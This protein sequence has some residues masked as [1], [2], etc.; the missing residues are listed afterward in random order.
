[1][2]DDRS[3]KEVLDEQAETLEA[4]APSRRQVHMNGW[5]IVILGVGT[6]LAIGVLFFLRASQT[7]SADKRIC[8]KVDHLTSALILFA[9]QNPKPPEGTQRRRDLDRF[10]EA[11]RKAACDPKNL[12]STP[13]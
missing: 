13:K 11:M 2:T 9:T 4:E 12:P 10:L 1:M 8:E 6:G 5:K 3:K 7:A